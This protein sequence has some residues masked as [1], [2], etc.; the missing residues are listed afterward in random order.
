MKRVNQMMHL[1]NLK[2]GSKCEKYG[3]KSPGMT[4]EESTPSSSKVSRP[5]TG[6]NNNG[7]PFKPVLVTGSNPIPFISLKPKD[8]KN[9]KPLADVPNHQRS[10]IPEL[11]MFPEVKFQK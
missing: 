3:V 4:R 6:S 5:A 10:Q 7:D 9:T 11:L 2:P 8:I 1:K